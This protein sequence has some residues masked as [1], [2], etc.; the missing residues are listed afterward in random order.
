MAIV[1]KE[2]LLNKISG[3][4]PEG[5]EDLSILEDISDTY[6]DLS[7]KANTDWEGKYNEVLTAYRTRFT[8][9]AAVDVPAT[10]P[11]EPTGPTTFE[12]LFTKEED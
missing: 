9:G 8:E 5:A 11:E 12:E 1:T 4:I 10:E 3:Y 6:D 7:S 2:A